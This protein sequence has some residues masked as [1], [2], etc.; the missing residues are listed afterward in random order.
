V[1]ALDGGAIL[2]LEPLIEAVLEGVR[3]TGWSLSGLQKTTSSMFE[4]RWEGDSTR[5]AYL[6]FHLPSGPVGASLD[7]FLDETS[8]GLDGNLA[9]VVDARTLAEIGE[10]EASLGALAGIARNRLPRAYRTPLTL[11]LH[12][13]GLDAEPGTAGAE[14]RFKVRIPRDRMNAGPSAVSEMVGA[15]AAALR[16]LLDDPLLTPFLDAG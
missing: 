5:S 16:G 3:P 7:V 13:E 8:R 4:G 2:T 15:S 10:V 1:S 9:L 6:F 14:I 11:R 12:L